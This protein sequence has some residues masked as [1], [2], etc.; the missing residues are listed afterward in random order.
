MKGIG[1]T[2]TRITAAIEYSGNGN[3]TKTANT[4]RTRVPMK[5][6][7]RS[8]R[9][10]V[11]TTTQLEVLQPLERKESPFQLSQ[12]S[13]GERQAVLTGIGRKLA[14]DHR[15]GDCSRFDRQGEAQQFE[16]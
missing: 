4:F 16:Q 14:Q 13:Q 12:F 9:A 11:A 5:A 15:G 1:A 10:D 8:Q 3:K 2:A 6:A 7:G